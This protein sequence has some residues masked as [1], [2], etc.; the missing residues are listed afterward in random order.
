[1]L[2]L[3]VKIKVSFDEVEDIKL[4]NIASKEE[5]DTKL[6]MYNRDELYKVAMTCKIFRKS[7]DT[8]YN[9]LTKMISYF[10]NKDK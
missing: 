10:E 5:R 4:L 8:K 2:L 7:Y 9:M 1:M 6:K 3:A